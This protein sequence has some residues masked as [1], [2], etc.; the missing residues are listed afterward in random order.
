M[1][2]CPGLSKYQPYQLEEDDTAESRLADR[3]KRL[4]TQYNIANMYC[5]YETSG[6]SVNR[7]RV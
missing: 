4:G 6:N 1:R 3:M 2:I 7:V 5:S